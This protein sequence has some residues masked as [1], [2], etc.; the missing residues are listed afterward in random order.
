MNL[1][2]K[3]ERTTFSFEPYFHSL[4]RILTMK[5]RFHSELGAGEGPVSEEPNQRAVKVDAQCIYLFLD[6]RPFG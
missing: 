5:P 1:G 2:L 6:E 3:Y 4:T